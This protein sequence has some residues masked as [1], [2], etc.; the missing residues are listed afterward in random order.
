MAATGAAA[1]IGGHHPA[2]STAHKGGV[3]TY[4]L[5]VTGAPSALAYR[6]A[7][8]G[9]AARADAAATARARLAANE[10]AQDRVV[11]A[12]H[13]RN[14]G[15][16]V[17]FRIGAVYNGIAV[18]ATAAEAKRMAS[19][20]GVRSVA[21]ITP[22]TV[23]NVTSVPSVKAPFAW[24]TAGG[25]NTGQGTKIGIIDTGIDYVHR[26]FGGDASAQSYTDATSAS[27]N[28]EITD[29]LLLNP[30]PVTSGATQ[31]FPSTKVT[32]VDFAGD[33]YNAGGSAAAKIPHADGNP[34]DCDNGVS[35]STI[36]H[37]T[38]VAGTAG[39]LGV[40]NDGTTFGGSYDGFDPSTVSPAMLVGPGVAPGAQ[41]FAL[42]VFGCAGSTSLSSAAA[43]WAVDPN[44]DGVP[45][46]H[47]DVLNLSLGSDYGR[48]YD[49]QVT[50]FQNAVA[51]GVDVAIAAGN[52]ADNTGILGGP[53][54]SPAVVTVANVTRP[55][56]SSMA[57]SSSRGP[58]L[59]G[60]LKPDIAAPGSSIASADAK[61]GTTAKVLTGTSM[62]TPHVAGALALMKVAHPT[63]TPLERKALLM[64]STSS[65]AAAGATKHSPQR[66]GAGVLDVQSALAPDTVAYADVT[67]GSV[68]VSFGA[69]DVDSTAELDRTVSVVNKGATAHTYTLAYDPRSTVPGVSYSFPDGPTVTVNPGATAT[70]RVHL[71]ATASAMTDS[72]DP[73]IVETQ[74]GQARSWLSEASG[75]VTLTPTSGPALRLP[76]YAAPKPVNTIQAVERNLKPAGAT[77]TTLL[78]HLAGTELSATSAGPA[79]TQY[80]PVLTPLELTQTSPRQNPVL[81][82]RIGAADL[83]YVGIG[84]DF[85]TT[86]ATAATI[87]FGIVA[88]DPSLIA[89][90]P[91]SE[92]DVFIDTNEDGTDDFYVLNTFFTGTD[93]WT[94]A[95]FTLGGSFSGT[96]PLDGLDRPSRR[97]ATNTNVLM[98]GTTGSQLGLSAGNTGFDYHVRTLAGGVVRDTTPTAHFD[99]AQPGLTFAGP[100][101]PAD[102]TATT[103]PVSYDRARFTADG[104]AGVLLMHFMGSPSTRADFIPV[105]EDA[106]PTSSPGGPYSIAE[107]SPLV[108]DGS[109]SS[110]PNGDTLA[111]TWDLNN[112]GTTDATGA[113]PTVPAATLDGLGLGDG[114]ANVTNAKLTVTD[115]TTPVSSTFTVDVTNVAPTLVITPPASAVTAGSPASFHFATTDP[116]TSDT[117]SGFTYKIDWDGD[118]T[119]D[120]ML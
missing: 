58:A 100:A 18:L 11:A 105:A 113:Q 17:V 97:G 71:S 88:W 48:P 21:E 89:T 64:N 12:L 60:R 33:A 41:L 3:G 79:T 49:P 26:D 118:G 15:Q 52:S 38:H 44:H 98:V 23:G 39:G 112:D 37:G 120:Q 20:A 24:S 50:V 42:R 53:G 109:G 30:V 66:Q 47:L 81:D 114:P 65:D 96:V 14:L 119:V 117:A 54:T 25:A 9:G 2:L 10:S 40:N 107:G 67:D 83:R 13:A 94:S 61:G 36:G 77:D 99:I 63:W 101:F 46:D 92:V 72:H 27:N 106:A 68:G 116:S 90:W 73:T 7:R 82:P 28:V 76:V 91:Q 74:S 70:F 110:D 16:G 31:I 78:L 55:P 32:G 95:T 84:S 59:D 62:A 57:S 1:A 19:I 22:L 103:V 104:A 6:Q 8:A 43:N 45:T 29:P 87:R 75:I 115:G 5:Q 111:Y 69:V 35:G 4:M 93:G 86:S 34:M 80:D 56:A 108:L 51:A 102:V 85:A